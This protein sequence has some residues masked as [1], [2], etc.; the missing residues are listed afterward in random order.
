VGRRAQI[1]Q[2]ARHVRR[3][4]NSVCHGEDAQRPQRMELLDDVDR[5]MKSAPRTRL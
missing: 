2:P 4:G 1:R 5:P 3:F